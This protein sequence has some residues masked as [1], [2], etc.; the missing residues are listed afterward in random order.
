MSEHASIADSSRPN[1]GRIYDFLLGGSH[2][3]EVDRGAAQEILKLLPFFSQ[4]AH[5]IRW[6]LGEAVR[7]LVAEGYTHFLDF[8]SGLP[9]MDH[10]HQ[11][12]PPGAKVIYSDIDPITVA[13]GQELVKDNSSVRYVVA[14]AGKAETV[15]ASPVVAEMFGDNRKVAIG[16]NGISWFLPDAAV[17]HSLK[18]LH[19]WAGRGSKLFV[20]YFDSS[21]IPEGMETLMQLY[22]K[23]GQPGLPANRGEVQGAHR[24]VE[25]PGS[26]HPCPRRVGRHGKD[27]CRGIHHHHWRAPQGSHPGQVGTGPA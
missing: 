27:R 6:F 21:S 14:D 16:F 19:D 25:C 8:A 13:Y 23:L 5:I 9:T 12:A 4:F 22:E 18:V 26:G 7:R 20:S 17:G 15:L 24:E 1:A 2:N 10:I 3:F 11:V